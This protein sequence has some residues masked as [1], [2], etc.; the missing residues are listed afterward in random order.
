MSFISNWVFRF[1][2]YV[3][4]DL[5]LYYLCEVGIFNLLINIEMFRINEFLGMLFF[6]GERG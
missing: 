6:R 4:G 1:V 2:L 5:N 3:I